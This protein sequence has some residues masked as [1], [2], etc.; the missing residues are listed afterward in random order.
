MRVVSALK[1]FVQILLNNKTKLQGI[2]YT[3]T[4]DSL[5]GRK[6]YILFLG[7]H[8]VNNPDEVSMDIEKVDWKKKHS[9][10]NTNYIIF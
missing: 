2:D 4:V 8:Y 7:A 10:K 5:N 6:L 9:L 3:D 1:N